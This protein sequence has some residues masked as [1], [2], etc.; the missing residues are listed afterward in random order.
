M[1]MNNKK[2]TFLK[3]FSCALIV[4]VFAIVL[5]VNYARNNMVYA[6]NVNTGV[7]GLTA[8]SSGDAIWT[9][10]NGKIT[11]SVTAKVKSGCISD[12]YTAR[13]GTL[14]FKNNSGGERLVSFEYSL[15]L[16]GGSVTVDGA[17]VTA[18]STF[19]KTLQANETVSIVIKSNEANSTPTEITISNIKCVDTS[20]QYNISFYIPDG[21]TLTFNGDVVTNESIISVRPSDTIIINATIP[22]TN[23][24]IRFYN[25]SSGVTLGASNPYNCNFTSDAMISIDIC[26]KNDPIF[27]CDNEFFADLNAADNY[28]TG[29]SHKNIILVDSGIISNQDNL[30]ISSGNLLLIP[31]DE[32]YTCYREAP[33]IVYGKGVSH[34]KQSVFKK[35]ELVNSNI[36]V[37]GKISVSCKMSAIGQNE[38]SWNGTP[39]GKY[40]CISLDSDSKIILTSDSSL[41]CWGYISGDGVVE[42]K[43]GSTVWE[44]F[45]LRCWR[46][47][48]ATSDMAGNSQKVFP[49]NQYYIQNIEC[50]LRLHSGASEKVYTAVNMSNQGYSASAVFIGSNDGVMFK[51]KSGYIEKKYNGTTDRLEI[52]IYGELSLSEFSLKIAGLP[53][54]GTLDLNTSSYVLPINSNISI[55]VKSKYLDG[56]DVPNGSKISIDQD[57]ALLPGCVID[58]D[59]NCTLTISSGKSMY[60]YDKDEWGAY[61]AAGQQL[62]VVGYS[63]V[64]GTDAKRTAA[65][66]VDAKIIVNGTMIFNGNLYTTSHGADICSTNENFDSN[67]GK[68]IFNSAGTETNTNQATQSGSAITYVSIPLNSAKFK[69]ANDTY[70]IPDS[71]TYF[72]KNTTFYYFNGEWSDEP[73][74]TIYLIRFYE[75]SNYDGSYIQK[76]YDSSQT[77]ITIPTSQDAANAGFTFDDDVYKVKAWVLIMNGEITILYPGETPESLPTDTIYMVAP[78]TADSELGIVNAYAFYGGLLVNGNFTYGYTYDKNKDLDDSLVSGIY[79]FANDSK[80]N[81]NYYF[82]EY[83]VLVKG[84]ST[85]SDYG[86]A[87]NTKDGY[88]YYISPS[89]VV[90][91][92]GLTKLVDIKGEG[93]MN[94]QEYYFYFGENNYAYKSGYYYVNSTIDSIKSGYYYFDEYSHLVENP[95]IEIIDNK[96]YIAGILTGYGLFELNGKRYYAYEDGTLATNVTLYVTSSKNKTGNNAYDNALLYFNAQGENTN[97]YLES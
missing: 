94:P 37:E 97:P 10:S 88:K 44:M 11:G 54:I 58:I 41:Y 83:G 71:G 82:D 20:I 32:A 47:G 75:D 33:E 49:M 60:V 38:S 42:A 8:D 19:N 86:L 15:I 77:M 50:T 79:S 62:V 64:N 55:F 72:P 53:L 31:F 80:I 36:T 63:T 29:H 26:E 95:E 23:K 89:G 12:T 22:N 96:C 1:E 14:I 48:T 91:S 39:T 85:T 46:G 66:L 74:A 7:E 65:S 61:A 67:N 35:L 24:F 57:L 93:D 34:V 5:F 28:S 84:N 51:I 21:C 73:S 76:K 4:I 59:K 13:N 69:N 68:V 2:L 52:S 30:R 17:S 16:S 3:Y 90:M 27:M 43:S 87:T 81:V 9:Y 70:L 92:I 6:A 45:Q 18:G 56:T 78:D 25:Y 40:G